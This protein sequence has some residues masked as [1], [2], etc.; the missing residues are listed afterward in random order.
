[1]DSS[2]PENF[3]RAADEN[4]RLFYTEAIGNP[5]CN[6]DDLEAI[7][8]AAA[9]H[10]V[11]LILDATTA[12][13][14]IGDPLAWCDAAVLSLTKIVGGHGTAIGGAIV[15]KG[16]F[17]WSAGNYPEITAPD[18]SYHGYNLWEALG[19]LEGG[20]VPYLAHKARIGMLHDV[21]PCISP[22]NVHEIM[23]GL[24]TLGLRG[25]RHCENALAVARFLEGHPAVGWVNYAGLPGHPDHERAMRY[26]PHGP[27]AVFGFGI[28]GGEGGGK[29]AARRFIESVKLCSHL[30]NILDART[31][32]IHPA[33]TTHSQCTP[34]ELEAAGV[35][36]DM[37]R[38]SVGL[39]HPDDIIADLDQALAS[40]R[41][42]S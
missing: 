34:E 2:D 15:D 6:V 24:E 38:I 14:P 29:A 37:V 13:P 7:H 35:G 27:S 39:E 33:S 5:R 9:A 22:M 25:P 18:A 17:D 26:F 8:A 4:T 41:K 11:P 12:P 16:T 32:V 20:P 28:A 19:G 40:A 3:S 31:L 21:G 42:M 36:E 30:A 23:N 10:G 1:V